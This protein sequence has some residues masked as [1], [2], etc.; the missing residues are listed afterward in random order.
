MDLGVTPAKTY[1]KNI[2]ITIEDENYPGID[3]IVE[4]VCE[5]CVTAGNTTDYDKA[6]W[7]H[8]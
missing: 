5:E 8:D 2:T 6:L 3:A 7:L 4:S 1:R